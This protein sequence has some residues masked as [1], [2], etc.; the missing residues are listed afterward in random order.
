MVVK[1]KKQ[2]KQ[3]LIY[4]NQNPLTV[5]SSSI[6]P[7]TDYIS[8]ENSAYEIEKEELKE[9]NKEEKDTERTDEQP[10]VASQDNPCDD[11][12]I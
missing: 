3:Q 10:L 8:N 6:S 2:G 9:A 1:V 12:E 5:D 7:P 4:A 11:T